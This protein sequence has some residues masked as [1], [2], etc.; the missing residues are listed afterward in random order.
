MR[1]LAFTRVCV[2]LGK[3]VSFSVLPFLKVPPPQTTRQ[4]LTEPNSYRTPYNFYIGNIYVHDVGTYMST[5]S[6]WRMHGTEV[7]ISV[8]YDRTRRCVST[9]GTGVIEFCLV[10]L[11][12]IW[13]IYFWLLFL[14]F[15]Q[16]CLLFFWF[17][18][19]HLLSACTVVYM[20]SQYYFSV[21]CNWKLKV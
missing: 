2:A 21:T 1:F 3:S 8:S 7:A 11:E 13:L 9:F 20:P 18:G 4:S 16:I 17:C 14:V 10:C 12:P 5:K 15:N 19:S 6:T